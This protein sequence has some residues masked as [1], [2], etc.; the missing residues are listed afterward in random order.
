M[1]MSYCEVCSK[2]IDTDF[3]MHDDEAGECV[4]Y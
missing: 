2:V 1:S 4:E 3:I